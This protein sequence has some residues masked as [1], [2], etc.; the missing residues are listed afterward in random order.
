[1]V[2]HSS[3]MFGWNWIELSVLS[4]Q[5]F[6]RNSTDSRAGSVYKLRSFLPFLKQTKK[7]TLLLHTIY[8]N[9]KHKQK[10]EF[11]IST[12]LSNNSVA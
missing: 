10:Q 3:V 2:E 4:S 6:G 1:M 9:F 12:N 11:A 7:L 8:K 5:A